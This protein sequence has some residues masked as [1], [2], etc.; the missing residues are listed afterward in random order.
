MSKIDFLYIGDFL[1]S[2]VI[3]GGELNDHELCEI[4]VA[5]KNRS[6]E[7]TIDLLNSNRDHKIIVSNFANLASDVKEYLA[8][9]RDYIIYEHDHKYL[10]SRNPAIYTNFTAPSVELINVN[11]Y[12][13]AAAVFCQSSF[14]KDIVS[15]NI[16]LSNIHSVSGNLWSLHS[17]EM[18]RSLC[19]AQKRNR[20]SVLDSN[21][22]H[23]NTSETSF[24]CRKKGFKYDLISSRDYNEFINLLSKNDK[25]ILLPKTPETM[26]R[27]VVEARMLGVKTITNKNIGASYEEWF[28]LKGNELIECMINKRK[29][30]PNMVL[31]I[32]Q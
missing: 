7:V 28:S 2:D 19:K 27:V 3:G 25:F 29:E 31:G 23:K 26:S 11:F 18:M 15:R 16:N 9:E 13:K 5:K 30:I 21:I 12:R 20:Y 14:H 22:D 6:H 10:R 8:E 24:Y 32:F 17:L 4:L 1:L